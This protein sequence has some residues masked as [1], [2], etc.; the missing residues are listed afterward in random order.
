M[1]E[2]LADLLE[3]PGPGLA[4]AAS[5]CRDLLGA[6]PREAREVGAF[7]ALVRGSDLASLEE[8]YTRTFDLHPPHCLDVGFQLFGESY[9]RGLFLVKVQRAVGAHAIGHK[10]V[11][12][13][14]LPVMLR[15][16]SAVGSEEDPRGLAEE[17][18][19]PALGKIR[20]AFKDAENPYRAILEVCLS[21]VMG[22]F[23]ID[24]ILPVPGDPV[25]ALPGG[26]PGRT[27]E[28]S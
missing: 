13:D 8:L 25:A 14:H 19:V 21:V 11:L 6:Y 24:R 4:Q 9:K 28:A 10:G 3:Y 2:A 12:P 17:A 27:L 18:I 22:E 20:E 16:L 5:R 23:A 1:F 7:A 15:L 26:S